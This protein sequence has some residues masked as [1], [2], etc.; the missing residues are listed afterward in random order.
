MESAT[1]VINDE[2]TQSETVEKVLS[3][4]QQR[5]LRAKERYLEKRVVKRAEER[6]KRKA[7]REARKE[8]G[9]FELLKRKR[10]RKMCDSTSKQRI[11]LD[12]SFDDLMSEKDQKRSVRQ[13]NWCYTANRHSAQPF[14]LH[15]V[16][17]NGP[18][19]KIYDNVE[20]AENQDV[21]CHDTKLEDTFKPE[22]IVYLSAE[23]D[24]VLETLDDSKVYVIGGLVDHN[25]HK[26]LCHKL[27]VE[28]KFGHAR[29]P[30]D[31]YVHLKTRRVLTIN[32]VYE[33]LVHFSTHGDWEKAFLSIVPGRKGML[34]K[35]EAEAG[36]G[37]ETMNEN[38]EAEAEDVEEND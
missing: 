5:K 18:S 2:P 35:A 19:R 28:K 16:G 26:G 14:Q 11:A 37:T 38:E 36:N 30:I 8:A 21:F 17:F 15:L 23:S 7:K 10:P 31:E 33:I 27:A 24:N 34:T 9:E 32:Q 3:K 12:M 22:E 6:A 13:I 20:G 29:L 25:F 1:E 4:N